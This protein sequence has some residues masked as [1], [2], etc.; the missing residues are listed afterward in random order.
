MSKEG[1]R[2]GSKERIGTDGVERMRLSSDDVNMGD[3][4][5]VDRR[6]KEGVVER[7][8]KKTDFN[9]VIVEDKVDSSEFGAELNEGLNF[10]ISEAFWIFLVFDVLISFTICSSSF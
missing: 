1:V 9:V 10:D 5:R 2:K 7:D 4:G 6:D 3:W 8:D